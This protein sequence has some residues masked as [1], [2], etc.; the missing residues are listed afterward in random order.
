M[1]FQDRINPNSQGVLGQTSNVS[2]SSTRTQPTFL[3][4]G[5]VSGSNFSGHTGISAD[6]DIVKLGGGSFYMKSVWIAIY[7]TT[8]DNHSEWTQWGYGLNKD[9]GYI[10]IL[11]TWRFDGGTVQVY[12]TTT[13]LASRPFVFGTNETFRIYNVGGT[14]WRVSRGGVDLY[15][16]DLNATSITKVEFY[17]EGQNTSASLTWPVINIK[18]FSTR[19]VSSVWTTVP[20]AQVSGNISPNTG[21]SIWPI[22][23]HAQDAS[24]P[25]GNIVLGG[26][27]SGTAG[28]ATLWS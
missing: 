18:N 13:F 12:P 4:T 25:V 7:Y 20:T 23:G 11:T 1:R 14:L 8:V 21:L 3:Y 17:I 16:V 2:A 28:L 19:N 22:K 9:L 10:N 26:R 24:I 15:E 6:I 5:G 27:G